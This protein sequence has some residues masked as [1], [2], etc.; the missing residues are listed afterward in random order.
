M[1]IAVIGCGGIG[2]VIAGVLVLHRLSVCCFEADERI[3]QHL[4]DRGFHIQGKKGDFQAKAAIYPALKEFKEVFDVII[5]A[6]KSGNLRSVF[7][8]AKERLCKNG[9]IMTIQ[10]GIEVLG[11]GEEF[12][13]V[14]IV[15]GAVGYNSVMLDYGEYYVTSEGG[16]TVGSLNRAEREDL[17]L[18]KNI[19]E[20]HIKI[21]IS[22][23]IPGVLWA[24]LII[25][26]G[27][28]GL[29]GAAGLLAGEL[30]GYKVARK[31]FYAVATEGSLLAEKLGIRLEKFGGGINPERFGNHKKGYPLFLRFLLLKIVGIK[32]RGLKSNIFHSIEKGKKTEVDFINGALVRM[33]EKAGF[34]TPVNSVLVHVIKEIEAGERKMD[35]Q[36]LYDIWEEVKEKN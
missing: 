34:P 28:T 20:P 9:F 26:C 15:A 7:V 3:L 13:G 25:V 23:N 4:K 6:V 11:L 22:E 10:N 32:Y 16:I 18:L 14:K 31:L 21:D 30:L 36:N 2:G 24:K 17:F 12:Q 5:I 33:G 29:G 1:R 27:V 35:V 8:E 19:F